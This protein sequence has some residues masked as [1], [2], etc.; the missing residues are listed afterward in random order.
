MFLGD[1]YIVLGTHLPNFSSNIVRVFRISP[2]VTDVA[3]QVH[4]IT[5]SVAKIQYMS[6]V[7]FKDASWYVQGDNKNCV[8]VDKAMNGLKELWK[9]QIV[10]FNLVGLEVIKQT[11]PSITFYNRMMISYFSLSFTQ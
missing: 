7:H 4:H 10:Q 6:N 2:N 9:R 8:T 1:N 11:K 5:K 3:T